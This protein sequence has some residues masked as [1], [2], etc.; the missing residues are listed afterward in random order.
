MNEAFLC[1][2]YIVTTVTMLTML[3]LS[4]SNVCKFEREPH[5]V[6]FFVKENTTA[7][8]DVSFSVWIYSYADSHLKLMAFNS[9]STKASR[10]KAFRLLVEFR[11]F[12]KTRYFVNIFKLINVTNISL[13][14]FE[15][16][17]F[18]SKVIKEFYKC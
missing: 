11:I 2:F 6:T 13:L 4:L 12:W 15:S 3:T 8:M 10:A 14:V 1:P 18:N 5:S 17:F 9:T 16:D 7:K